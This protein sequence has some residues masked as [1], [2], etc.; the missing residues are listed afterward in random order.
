MTADSI[1]L[2]HIEIRRRKQMNECEQNTNG[3]NR[4]RKANICR[5]QSTTIIATTTFR[6][7]LIGGAIGM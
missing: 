3:H 6:M 7:V 4:I 2:Q 5:S 1:V